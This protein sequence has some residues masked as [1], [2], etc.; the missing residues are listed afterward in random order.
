MEKKKFAMPFDKVLSLGYVFY[1]QFLEKK[2]E[3]T[4]FSNSFADPFAADFIS[5]LKAADNLPIN[6]DDLAH[7]GSLTMMLRKKLAESVQFYSRFMQYVKL[8]WGNSSPELD[9]FGRNEFNR[10]RNQALKMVHILSLA[11]KLAEMPEYKPN[12]LA[13][14]FSQSDITHLQT[15]STELDMALSERDGFMS[16]SSRRSQE[17]IDA[18]NKFWGKMVL[19]SKTA[20]MIFED[21][22]AL[23]KTFRLYHKRKKAKGS[24]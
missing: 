19:I 6:V 3:F 5:E 24:T 2:S 4:A 10:E 15:L 22:P 17:R 14:G 1:N 18:F 11:N 21:S 23:V 13:V 20:K 7:Q 12:L 8:A 9:V 16:A